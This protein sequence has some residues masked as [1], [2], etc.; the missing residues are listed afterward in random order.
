MPGYFFSSSSKP[1]VRAS[2]AAEPGGCVMTSTS[3]L[4]SSSALIASA[5][6]R[7]PCALSVRICV[8][9]K[10]LSSIVWSTV[11]ILVP[12]SAS[13]FI[14]AISAFASVGTI[15]ATAGVVAATALTTGIWLSAANWSGADTVQSEAERLCFRLRATGERL[16]ERASLH[17]EHQR[18]SWLGR[19]GSR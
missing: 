6:S 7:P 5:A 3:P 15:T 18:D 1:V 16:V 12:R 14:G 2:C 17:A 13:C 4:P 9:T 8:W 19:L 11:T 10:E